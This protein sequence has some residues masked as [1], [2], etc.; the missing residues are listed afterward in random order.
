D[1]IY[2]YRILPSRGFEYVSPSVKS[3]T[4]YLPEDFYA[5][6][7][8][9]KRLT[10]AE[11]QPLLEE[12]ARV[13]RS[14]QESLRLRWRRRDGTAV[15]TEQR[16][17]RVFDAE[18]RHIATEGIVRDISQRQQAEEALRESERRLATVF[19]ASPLPIAITRLEDRVFLNANSAY[20]RLTGY[21]PA[22][23]IGRN[24]GDLGIWDDAEA[25]PFIRDTLRAGEVL[26]DLETQLRRRDG[27]L[28]TFRASFAALRLGGADCVLS[29]GSDVTEQRALEDRL[30]EQERVLA[31]LEEREQ[32][33]MDLHDGAIQS[34]YAVGLGLG[35][36]SLR[37]SS[38]EVR[39]ALARAIA[40]I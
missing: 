18:G 31:L 1:M 35:A 33:A 22:E 40:Q 11:D 30:A 8:M 12:S 21:S 32:I 38:G 3:L 14:V 26:R 37:T 15:W 27:Q 28:R 17:V 20:C 9:A 36:Q 34:L 10:L 29:I 25:R 7:D 39:A 4:G 19:E 16:Y 2:R 13:A 5:A 23:L 6:P 24:A